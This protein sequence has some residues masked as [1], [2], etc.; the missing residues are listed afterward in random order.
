MAF[1]Q[2][3]LRKMPKKFSHGY[4]YAYDIFLPEEGCPQ[5]LEV[6]TNRG[7]AKFWSEY[8]KDPLVLAGHVRVLEEKLGWTFLG[9]EGEALRK[10]YGNVYNHVRSDL[11]YLLGEMKKERMDRPFWLTQIKERNPRL[12]RGL[13]ELKD[14]EDTFGYFAEVERF[15]KEYLA[16]VEKAQSM[17]DDGWSDFLGW[18]ERQLSDDN[19]YA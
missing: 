19:V 1:V 4:G 13:L 14:P 16:K 5:I 2:E 11:F 12:L 9:P 17:D 3:F 8:L 15:A 18:A 10:G 6:N 7:R